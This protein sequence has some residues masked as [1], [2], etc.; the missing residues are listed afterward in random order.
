LSDLLGGTAAFLANVARVRENVK[1]AQQRGLV[2]AG[3]LVLNTS[4]PTV[5]HED[6]DFERTGRVTTDERTAAVSYKDVRYPGEAARLHEDL[7]MRH[8]SGRSAK[9]LEKAMTRSV[10]GVRSILG[11]NIRSGMG[12]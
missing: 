11:S 3:A 7:E 12:G 5:P 2:A 4:N 1:K 9:F 8:D 10:D 6:G